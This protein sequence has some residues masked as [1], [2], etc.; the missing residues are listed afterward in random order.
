[1]DRDSTVDQF[2]FERLKAFFAENFPELYRVQSRIHSLRSFS[3]KNCQC[4]IKR[5]DELSF[6]IS[7]SKMRKY[8]SLLPYLKREK[9]QEALLIGGAYSNNVLGLTQLLIENGIKPT[10]LLRKAGNE[11]LQGNRLFIEL[12]VEQSAIRWISR[13]DWSRVEKIAATLAEEREKQK[14]KVKVIPEGAFL[15]EALD[16]ALTLSADIVRNEVEHQMAFDHLFIDSGTGLQAAALILG[17]SWLRHR[18]TV[19]VLLLADQQPLFIEKLQQLHP[20]FSRRL[21]EDIPFPDNFCLHRPTNAAAFGAVNA[22][23]FDFIVSFARVEGVF[24]DPIYSAKLIFEGK[25]IIETDDFQGN[26]LFIHSGGGLSLSGF[27]SQLN[28]HK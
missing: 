26:V 13:E 1:M 5:D 2:Y 25:K 6:S 24:L 20:L 21:G 23:V 28:Y 27:Q 10:L 8:L 3:R 14:V 9:V 22:K 15:P 7:G 4:F 12:L 17:M 11:E 18:A 19:H 16:G